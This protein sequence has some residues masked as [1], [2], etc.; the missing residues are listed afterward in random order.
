MLR[1]TG[2]FCLLP[3]VEID[4]KGAPARS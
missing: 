3:V 1:T 4:F 2:L